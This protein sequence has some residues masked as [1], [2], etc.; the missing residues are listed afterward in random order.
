MYSIISQRLSTYLNINIAKGQEMNKSVA[1]TLLAI[2]I[3]LAAGTGLYFLNYDGEDEN[4]NEVAISSSEENQGVSENSN[5]EVI[6]STLIIGSPNAKVTVIEYIDYK[7]PNCNKFHRGAA[8]K[9]TTEYDSQ[10]NFEIRAYPAFGPDSGRAL[11]GA[12]CA[13]DQNAFTDY[14]NTVM[15]Y[16]WDNYYSSENYQIEI[17]DILTTDLLV[18]LSGSYVA[19][20]ESFRQCIDSESK[21]YLIDRDL[22]LAADDGIRGTPGFVI[23]EQSFIG[24]QPISVFNALIDRQLQ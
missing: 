24:L 5:P 21:N 2:L 14:H 6:E 19:D 10:V 16:I 22:L 23:G 7:C 13:N 4:S 8:Q 1:T 18:E 3:F 20:S 12:Y 15:N 17:E 11:R 9:I